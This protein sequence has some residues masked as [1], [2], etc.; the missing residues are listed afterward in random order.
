MRAK[1]ITDEVIRRL[2]HDLHDFVAVNYANADM[3]AHTGNLKATIRAVETVDECLGKLAETVLA[4]NGHLIITGDHG[5]AEV[6]INEETG[7]IMTE[8]TSNP[9]P[10]YVISDEFRKMKVGHGMLGDIAPT[11]LDMMDIPK[12]PEM[13]GF[14]LLR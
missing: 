6:M 5:H 4:K 9:V 11:I 1:V 7:E 10:F 13:T 8:H 12:P 2:N 3:V 14:S